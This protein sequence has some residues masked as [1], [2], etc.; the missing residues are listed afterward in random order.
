MARREKL[1]GMAAP[2]T[3]PNGRLRRTM[4]AA[5][6]SVKMI[7]AAE[8]TASPGAKALPHPRRSG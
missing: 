1:F 6:T 5:L 7:V 8:R 2:A 4:G 3:F